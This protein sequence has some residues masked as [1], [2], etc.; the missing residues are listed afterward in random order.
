RNTSTN[1]SA[2]ATGKIQLTLPV[3]I[4][5]TGTHSITVVWITVAT[6]SVNLTKGLCAGSATIASTNCTRFA[7]AFVHGFATLVD[8]T[9]GSSIRVQNWPGNFTAVWDNTTCA[10]LRCTSST[11]SSFSSAL[12]TGRAFWSWDWTSVSLV[13]TH[14]YVIQMFLFG[15]AQVTLQVNGATL[16]GASG[17]AQFNSGTHGNDEVLSSVSIN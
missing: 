13:S 6:G 17:N 5:T 12:H 10:F 9:N 16:K 1:N 7:Q 8:R 3:T 11:S 15:G 14:K 4:P 2:M